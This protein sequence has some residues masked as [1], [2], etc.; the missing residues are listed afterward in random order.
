M[1]AWFLTMIFGFILEFLGL[2]VAA[3][4]LLLTWR[5]NANGRSFLSP[6]IERM[7]S[8]IRAI[9]GRPTRVQDGGEVAAMSAWA[10]TAS[11]Y[12]PFIMDSSLET[13]EKFDALAAGLN[14][15]LERVTQALHAVQDETKK[16]E[17]A[18]KGLER[19][20]GQTEQQVK[21]YSQR[22]VV[23]GVP[24]AVV[25]LFAA[26]VGLLCQGVATVATFNWSTPLG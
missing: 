9:L 4:G 6:R 14:R 13:E 17:A 16:R 12:A 5:E 11:G 8:R 25:G 10:G 21:S 23:D 20:I 7:T 26:A 22:L 1:M 18:D 3:S 15:A 19:R 24:R 2:G